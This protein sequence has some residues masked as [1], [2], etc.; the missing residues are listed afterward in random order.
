MISCW[1]HKSTTF[2]YC[3]KRCLNFQHSLDFFHDCAPSLFHIGL[4]IHQCATCKQDHCLILVQAR[5]KYPPHW[6]PLT[7][8]YEAMAR[9]DPSTGQPRGYIGLKSSNQALSLAY[10][11]DRRSDHIQNAAIMRQI[12]HEEI[13]VLQAVVAKNDVFCCLAHHQVNYDRYFCHLWTI[14]IGR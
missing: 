7:L 10:T 3:G 6:V 4:L 1:C 2:E 12:L 11:L 8:M 13:K 9:I 5:F 14:H